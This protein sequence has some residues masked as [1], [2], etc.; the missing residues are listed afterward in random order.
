[1]HPYIYMQV[2]NATLFAHA[3]I[4]SGTRECGRVGMCIE[5]EGCIRR[6]GELAWWRGSVMVEGE[7]HGKEREMREV[8]CVH[9]SI[10]ARA[11]N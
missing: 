6:G 4:Y 5:G 10:A 2:L 9:H 8:H 3:V 7:C 1:M 11:F